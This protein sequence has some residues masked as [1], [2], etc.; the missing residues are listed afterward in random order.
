M[1]EPVEPTTVRQPSMC[2]RHHIHFTN[3]N[4]A[5]VS[6]RGVDISFEPHDENTLI[7]STFETSTRRKQR[8]D[9]VWKDL[10]FTVPVKAKKEKKKKDFTD[11][12]SSSSAEKKVDQV[13]AGHREILRNVSGAV[14]AGTMLA[15]MG[16]SGAGKTSLLNLLA[17]RITTSKGATATGSV[18]V[19]NEPRDYHKF[20]KLA[21]YVLQDDDMFTELTVEE[22]LKYAALLRLPADMSREKKLLR[23]EKVIQELGLGK[24]KSTQIG[25]QIVRG[26]SGGEKKRVNI[27]TE[28]V[29]D[30]SCLFLDE[31][32]TGL[33]SFNALNVMTSLRH[34]ASNGRTVISTIHQPRSSIFAL[35]DQLCLLSE[36]RVMYFGPAKD[37]VPYFAGLSFR[38]PA[39]F[40]PADFFLDLLSIDPRSL[41][42][43]ANTKARV[44]YLG[45]KFESYKEPVSID[46]TPDVEGAGGEI[47]GEER[48]VH[49]RDRA[50][51]STWLNEFWVL[52]T[53]A[54][55]LA[56][57]ER[58]AN[59]ARFGQVI[60]FSVILGL[61][62]LQN[63][64]DEDVLPRLSLQ[65]VLFFIIINQG[66]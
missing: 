12:E 37:A 2:L 31:P 47:E 36:G 51:Q 20:K 59:I 16:S 5:Q 56:F 39:Q 24:V 35:F 60:F 41:D 38:S 25:N 1:E 26:I 66:K 34:L 4:I 48:D 18:Y 62:W 61:I 3:Q 58:V 49:L 29:T 63:G 57:R 54:V 30:P 55:K 45:D 28:L 44:Q 19:N 50:F 64:N 21:A 22:Q 53:R 27:G 15:V 52:C 6:Y 33:D 9:L 13:P 42:R 32:T 11:F 17:G 7:A 46:A 8:V 10:C 40:N 23:V 43:E 14:R 65:G